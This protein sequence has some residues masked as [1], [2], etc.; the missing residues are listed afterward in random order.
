MRAFKALFIANVK[1]FIRDRMALFWMLAFPVFFI[2]LFGAIFSQENGAS[3]DIGL[4]VEDSGP[5]GV[6]IAETFEKVPL[7]TIWQGDLE[8]ELEALKQGNRRAVVVLPGKLSEAI[9]RK[10]PCDIPV[11][12]DPSNQFT[13]QV[14]VS[15][16]NQMIEE[17]DRYISG[18]PRILRIS[19]QTILSQRLRNIDYLLPGILA[20][21]LMQLGIFGTAIPLIS[22]RERQVLRRLSVT[23]LSRLTFLAADVTRQL[24]TG[25]TQ[26]VLIISIGMLVFHVQ[27]IG[28]W[29]LLA[30][31]V[32]LGAAT[33]I[34]LGFFVAAIAPTE[35]SG[36]AIAQLINFPMLFLSGIFFPVEMMPGWLRP[37]MEA[38]PLTY[39]GDALRQVMVGASALH[40]LW[41]DMA[42]LAGWL[43][44][45]TAL[46]ARF[47]RWE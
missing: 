9:A 24:L 26:M 3:F 32:A 35:E 36:H 5:A 30:G 28:S 20:M 23:P 13:S 41:V 19:K 2:L 7:F 4:V 25:L 45:C 46:S 27:V 22:L 21:A 16:I 47:F 38:M 10:E 14:V 15:I 42:V 31:F 6:R 29:R 12:Y 11:Y 8:E 44:A 33:F 37:V 40:P 1:G 39:L 18:A 34:S 17:T 43:L